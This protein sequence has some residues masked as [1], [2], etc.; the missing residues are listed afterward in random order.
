MFLESS[1]NDERGIVLRSFSREFTVVDFRTGMEDT[2]GMF[3]FL[4]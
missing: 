2:R 4:G 3:F 1:V